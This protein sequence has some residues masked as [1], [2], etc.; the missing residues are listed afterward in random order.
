MGR[1][2]N[3]WILI[4]SLLMAAGF[5][6]AASLQTALYPDRI[7]VAVNKGFCAGG[8]FPST[9]WLGGEPVGIQT[10][11][12]YCQGHELD[13]GS[14][15]TT[16]F[17]A[18]QVLRLYLAGYET[19]PSVHLEIE[20]ISDGVAL[21][22]RPVRDAGETWVLHEFALPASWNGSSVRIRATDNAKGP[23]GWLAFS[24][25]VTANRDTGFRDALDLLFRTLV[26]FVLIFLP[27]FAV[28]AI[29]ALSWST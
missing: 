1:P 20:R 6:R 11:G 7:A 8:A 5:A 18:P 9:K 23:G 2:F 29:F 22:I 27:C 17:Q 26:H 3:R 12:S 13:T 25:P 16:A 10:W 14:L 28:C 24:E 15:T 19:N 21:A 4:A